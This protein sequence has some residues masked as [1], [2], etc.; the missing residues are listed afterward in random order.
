VAGS[1]RSG[2]RA[3]KLSDIPEIPQIVVWNAF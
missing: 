3:P 1:R 2:H